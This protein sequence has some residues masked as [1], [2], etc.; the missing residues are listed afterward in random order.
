MILGFAVVKNE[1]DI[2]EAMI[3]QNLRC[4]DRLVVVDNGSTDRTRDIVGSLI[5]EGL[6]CSLDLRPGLDHPQHEIV[7]EALPRLASLF[8]PDRIV[9][10]DADEVIRADPAAFRAEMT[11][12][13]LIELP[14]MTYVPRPEDDAGLLN[15]LERIRHRRRREKPGRSKIALPRRCLAGAVVS[16]GGHRLL[17]AQR[18][19][20]HGQR[21]QT[22]H[23]AHF[24]IRSA[25]QLASKAVIGS[26]AVRLRNG[27]ARTDGEAGQWHEMAA[28]VLSGGQ[29]GWEDIGAAAMS[30]GGP[31][32][33]R[34]VEDPIGPVA[35][36][37]YTLPRS[38][39]WLLRNVMAYTDALIDELPT[40]D[41]ADARKPPQ[42]RRSTITD[43]TE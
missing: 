4:L 19:I 3:R 29:L 20:I 43:P 14:W 23:L 36:L 6:A 37:R 40:R 9:L 8:D 18:R 32:P 21:S 12:D 41:R 24:P 42:M 15:P 35:D 26:W 39:T 13:A 10:L 34:L 2:I 17:D 1:D 16:K 27:H 38:E 31:V 22:A 28:R 33:S 5:D 25:V 7:A 30:Y 11:G